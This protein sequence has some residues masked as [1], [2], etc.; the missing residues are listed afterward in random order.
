MKALYAAGQSIRVEDVTEPTIAEDEVLVEVAACGFC[1]SDVEYYYGKAGR[2]G[3]RQGAARARP[4]VLGQGRRPRQIAGTY[5]LEEG[6]GRLRCARS[7]SCGACDSCGPGAPN[8]APTWCLAETRATVARAVR[9]VEG[10]ARVQAARHAQ[11][12]AGCI[13]RDARGRGQCGAQGRGRADDFAV[14]Y[15][16]GAVAPRWCSCS[17][18]RARGLRSSARAAIA[19]RRGEG[20]GGRFRVRGR[21]RPRR[22]EPGGE[23]RGPLADRVIVATGSMAANRAGPRDV[24]GGARPSSSWASP[25][26][27]TRFRCRVTSLIQD[28]TIASPLVSVPVAADDRHCHDELDTGPIITHSASLDG[29]GAAIER[30]VNREEDVLKR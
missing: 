5:G 3:R 10:G 19:C 11:R 8:F 12:R 14:V 23:G 13:R 4:R 7:E 18:T 21:R 25:A 29:I 24:R 15:G 20:A 9:E 27:R 17:R 22:E 1:G 26:W 28:K 2:H 30:V 16:P 6:T